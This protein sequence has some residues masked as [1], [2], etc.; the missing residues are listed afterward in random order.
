M[1]KIITCALPYANGN[2][3]IGHFFE[4]TCADIKSR[5]LTHTQQS[6]LFVSGDDCH[7][8]ATTLYCQKNNLDI[9]N[10]LDKQYLLHQKAY[11]DL[12]IN[13]SSFSKTNNSLHKQVVNW[14]IN[15]IKS[16]EKKHNVSLLE[17][18]DVL[19]WYDPISLQFLPDRY[20]KGD[21]PHC[22]AKEQHPEICENCNQP[23]LADKIIGAFNVLTQNPVTLKSTKHLTLN[24]QSFYSTLI[25]NEKLLHPSIKNKIL[26]LNDNKYI[27]ISR[28]APYYGIEIEGFEDLTNQFFYVWFDAP[29]AYLSFSYEIWLESKLPN[30]DSFN[31]FLSHV[32]FEHFIGKDI[33]YFHTFL[34]LNLLKVIC[35]DSKA[36]VEKINFHGWI[37]LDK[38][39]FSKSKGHHFDLSQFSPEQ[40]DAIRLYFFSKHD[41]SIQDN[42][43]QAQEVYQLYNQTVVNGLANFYARSTKIAENN[44][45][46]IKL[47]AEKLNHD[48]CDL[49]DSGNYKKLYE[50]INHQLAELNSSFQTLQLWKE[51]N[52]N[53]I[54]SKINDFLQQWYRIYQVLCFVCPSLSDKQDSIL[55]GQFIHISEKLDN[56]S[57]F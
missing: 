28:D 9:Q 11:S 49:L 14:C 7:G 43:F 3:H 8:A 36:Q 54:E 51:T 44:N 38:I 48:Y 6:H 27:D 53:I 17:V 2:L 40:I 45:I 46:K 47:L 34:W 37:T 39:K 32:R 16:Y 35:P 31:E 41:G 52:P 57:L 25:E 33:A 13:F 23:I 30:H 56:F 29:L 26:D 15:N 5:Y 21:C 18:R 42:E 19:S 22:G 10:H 50:T 12:K 24:T 1:N 20:I 4:A 55:N